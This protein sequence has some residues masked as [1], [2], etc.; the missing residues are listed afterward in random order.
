MRLPWRIYADDPNTPQARPYINAFV[1]RAQDRDNPVYRRIVELYHDPEVTR[2]V[3][4]QSRNTAVI[5]DLP[6]P[7]L[8]QITT[9]LEEVLRGGKS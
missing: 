2:V 5:V 3:V 9:D 4:A 6:A 1:A 8:E 7:E